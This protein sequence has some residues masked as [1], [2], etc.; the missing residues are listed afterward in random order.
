MFKLP[1]NT[2]TVGKLKAK[3]ASM[4]DEMPV[5]VSIKEMARFA[6][7]HKTEEDI[8]NFDGQTMDVFVVSV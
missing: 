1:P 7:L 5:M 6:K 8:I 3:L 2:L 4:P